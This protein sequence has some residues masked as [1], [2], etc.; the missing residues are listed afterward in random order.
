MLGTA[1]SRSQPLRQ[2]NTTSHERINVVLNGPKTYQDFALS[3]PDQSPRKDCDGKMSSICGVSYSMRFAHDCE[4]EDS[5]HSVTVDKVKN[6]RCFEF[7]D[8]SRFN[9]F[10]LGGQKGTAFGP[11]IDKLYAPH[12]MCF[13]GTQNHIPT[14]HRPV[15]LKRLL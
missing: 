7:L 2:H 8:L 5:C 14:R 12:G 4:P 15:R 1:T 10:V 9:Y 6:S 11:P 13:D 3:I